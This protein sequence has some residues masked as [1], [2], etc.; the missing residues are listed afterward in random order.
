MSMYSKMITYPEPGHMVIDGSAGASDDSDVEETCSEPATEEFPALAIMDPDIKK[1]TINNVICAVLA[2][3]TNIEE[4][5]FN[6][7]F[8][9]IYQNN[10]SG[11]FIYGPNFRTIAT[12]YA[13][14]FN[15][16]PNLKKFT[17]KQHNYTKEE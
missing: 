5:E 6:G 11:S 17:S 15:E 9:D 1:I 10:S 4:V 16:F 2:L 3:H 13:T 12:Q 8:D 14:F 7:T